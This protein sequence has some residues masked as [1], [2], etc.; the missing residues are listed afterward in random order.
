MRAPDP[1]VFSACQRCPVRDPA[2]I[3]WPFNS[4]VA[5]LIDDS[6]H[7]NKKLCYGTVMKWKQKDLRRSSKFSQS[8]M[9]ACF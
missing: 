5:G 1:P 3:G 2:L 6:F 9:S 4:M 7:K 8:W